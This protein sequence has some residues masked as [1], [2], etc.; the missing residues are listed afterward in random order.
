MK[1]SNLSFPEYARN[2]SLEASLPVWVTDEDETTYCT[3]KRARFLETKEHAC[4]WQCRNLVLLGFPLV[5][6]CP[7]QPSARWELYEFLYVIMLTLVSSL[8]GKQVW[9]KT[10]RTRIKTRKVH[11]QYF[12][13]SHS[14]ELS[15]VCL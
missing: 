6:N 14:P 8:K 12:I 15:S 2:T 1:I 9:E 13:H 11:C 4:T 5:P 7:F 3:A 10:F